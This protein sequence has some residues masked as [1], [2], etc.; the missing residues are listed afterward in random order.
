[1]K[2]DNFMLTN[3]QTCPTKY[4][5]RIDEDWSPRRKSAALGFGAVMHEGLGCWYKNSHLS[6]VER[7][8]MAIEIMRSKW[9]AEHPVDDYRTLGKAIDVM[10]DYARVYPSESFK[11]LGADTGNP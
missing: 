4:Q 5:L 7:L 9:P 11:V 1:M 2:V 6:N 3:H 8:E 10:S